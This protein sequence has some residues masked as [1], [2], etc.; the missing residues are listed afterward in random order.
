MSEHYERLFPGLANS[1]RARVRYFDDFLKASIEDGLDQL[2]ILGAG[3]DTR[4]YRIDELKGK[5]KTFEVD[6]PL[7][8]VVKIDKIKEIF[9]AIPDHVAYV[10]VDFDTESLGQKLLEKGYDRSK[11]TLF[12][13][14]GLIMYI[15]LQSVDDTLYFIAGNSRKGSSIIFDYYPKSLVDGTSQLETAKNIRNYLIQQGE[16]LQCGIDDG[17]P[18]VSGRTRLLRC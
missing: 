10:S 6:H 11:K 16:P 13:M 3:Y 8:Q 4:A 1:I 7:T 12:I 5:V 17:H 15:P 9:G 2:V 14:E 18:G